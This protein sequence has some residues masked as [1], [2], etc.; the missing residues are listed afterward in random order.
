ME[1]KGKEKEKFISIDLFYHSSPKLYVMHSL[2][3]AREAR[4]LRKQNNV[5]A[6]DL[7]TDTAAIL[8]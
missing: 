3:E 8:N 2:V 4:F 1:R 6:I 5:V 7:F